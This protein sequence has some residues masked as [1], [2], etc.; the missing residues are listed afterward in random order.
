MNQI[1]IVIIVLIVIVIV[2]LTIILLKKPKCICKIPPIQD[3]KDMETEAIGAEISTLAPIQG[4]YQWTWNKSGQP[5]SGTDTIVSFSGWTQLNT[6]LEQS[7]PQGTNPFLSLGG[8]NEHGRFT[9]EN[10]ADI[11]S[12]V[13]KIVDAGYKGV[14]FDVEVADTGLASVFR[15]AFSACKSKGLQVMVTTSHSAPYGAPDAAVLVQSWIEDTNIDIISPQLYTTGKET[16][17]KYT[18]TAGV[19][20]S[21][22]LDSRATFAPSIVASNQYPDAKLYFHSQEGITCGG[23]FVWSQTN[24]A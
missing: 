5:P 18:P 11:T 24:S 12:N 16:A 13:S 20:W 9:R 7:K 8:G 14:C 15:D 22:Y 6:A 4:W 19:P 17:P 23:Y 21:K 2:L 1:G 10:L 3:T